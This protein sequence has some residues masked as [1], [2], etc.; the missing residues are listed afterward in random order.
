MQIRFSIFAFLVTAAGFYTDAFA[1]MPKTDDNQLKKE[2]EMTSYEKDPDAGAVILYNYGESNIESGGGGLQLKTL[3]YTRAKIFK[4]SAF[5]LAEVEVAYLDANASEKISSV[6]GITYYLEDGKVKSYEISKKDIVESDLGDGWKSIKFTLPQ[7]KEG[8]VFEYSYMLIS[9]SLGAIRPW[10]FQ[11]YYPTIH[12]EY[13]TRIPEWYRFLPLMKGHLALTSRKSSSYSRSVI[14]TNFD[15]PTYGYGGGSSRSEAIQY[16]GE[17]T[18]YVMENVPAFIRE[19]YMT[20]P[21]DYLSSLQ[22][23]LQSV[24]YPQQPPKPILGSWEQLAREFMESESFGLRLNNSR[25]RK[26]V[27]E[28][29][30]EGKSQ[31]EQAQVIYDFVRKSMGWNQEFTAYVSGPLHLAFEKKEGSSAEINMILIDMLLEAGFTAQPVLISTRTH[32]KI[33]QI[34]PIYSQFNHVIAAVLTD[35]GYV[36]LDAIDDFMPFGMLPVSD[37]NESGFLVHASNPSWVDIRPLHHSESTWM[38][39]IKLDEEGTLDGRLT[40]TYHGYAAADARYRLSK[41]NKDEKEFIKEYITDDWSDVAADEITTKAADEPENPFEISLHL[42]GTD[43]VNVA[44]D[45]IY[46][47]PLLSVAQKE[48]PFKLKE[49]TYPVD[50]AIPIEEKY[51]LNMIIPEGYKV[52][53]LPKATK[54]VLPDNGATFFYQAK[55]I[56]SNMIQLNCFTTIAQT[57]FFPEEYEYI[58]M[59]FDHVVAKQG[60]QIVLRK[61]E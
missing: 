22:F 6:K 9:E 57:R 7:L 2:L 11:H 29:P 16:N 23:Q 15:R 25:V 32:G 27:K 33:Q 60:E 47:Q 20:T 4:E 53:E 45:F 54:V 36:F 21:S 26:M 34:Y 58:R 42:T 50:F 5:D 13:R 24:H 17:E 37:L 3:H 59:F 12:N 61:T 51:I 30:L 18:I 38:I 46:I 40:H 10:R 56:G 44:G 31:L 55:D 39:N 43:F 19:P 28:L 1:Q 35:N 8:A 48:N 49:R 52:E 41:L 14:F